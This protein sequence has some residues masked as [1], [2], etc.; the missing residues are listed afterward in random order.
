MPGTTPSS[1]PTCPFTGPHGE[2]FGFGCTGSA[3]GSLYYKALG[4][5]APDTAVPI[6][7][8]TTGPFSNLQPYL[9]WSQSNNSQTGSGNYTFSFNSGFKGSNTVPNFLYV[10]PMIEGKI[11]G[12]PAATGTGLQ[13]NPGGQTVYDPVT[14]VTWLANADLA[15]TNSFGL[16]PCKA[17]GNPKLCVNDDGAMNWD[18]ASQFVANMNSGA[19]YLGQT[20][21]ELP[22]IDSSCDGYDCSESGNPMGELFYRQL[23][24]S[25]GM[26]AVTA[27]NIDVGPF[28]HLQPYLYWGC[29]GATIQGPCQTTGP[30][31]GFEWSFSFGNGFQGTDIL[32]NDLYVTA[33]FAGA[34]TQ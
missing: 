28:N 14:N 34:G 12:T 29:L 31:S 33:Y 18:S 10:L 27:P 8:T 4:F 19:G 13:V 11:P 20:N 15:A 7:G 30:V 5:A 9:Y 25:R 24:L 3:L 1:D 26:P 17:P 32:A 2:S 23:G 6:P 21:W 22:P 16:P